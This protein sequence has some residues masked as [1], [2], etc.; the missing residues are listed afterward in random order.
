M[1]KNVSA[2][3]K[4]IKIG[5]EAKTWQAGL[6]DY[7]SVCRAITTSDARQSKANLAT[8]SICG[9]P[10]KLLCHLL[11]M[12]VTCAVNLITV[13]YFSTLQPIVGC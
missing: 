9:P 2:T 11:M 5:L 13:K 7:V 10:S 3:F 6:E 1:P 12:L 4:A 8:R